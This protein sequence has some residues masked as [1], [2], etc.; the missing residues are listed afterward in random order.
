ME[1]AIQGQSALELDATGV[2][3]VVIHYSGI[4]AMPVGNATLIL[5]NI[6]FDVSRWLYTSILLLTCQI[7][8]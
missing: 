2:K 4:K 1:Q 7:V 8:T 6:V 3:G 5:R